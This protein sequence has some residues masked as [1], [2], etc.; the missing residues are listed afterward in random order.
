MYYISGANIYIMSKS[1]TRTW[2]TI[3]LVVFI[4]LIYMAITEGL[5][6]STTRWLLLIS[7]ASNL[8]YIFYKKGMFKKG[9]LRPDAETRNK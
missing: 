2:L 6:H 4:Y 5:E 1:I 3:N 8:L 7:S 9:A